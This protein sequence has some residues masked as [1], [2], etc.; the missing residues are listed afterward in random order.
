MWKLLL[1]G[2]L[3]DDKGSSGPEIRRRIKKASETFRRLWRVWAM[4]GLPLK[5]KGRLYSAFVHSMRLYN[6]EV[7]NIT[8]TE[9]KALVG[10]NGYLM[11]RLVGEVERSADNKRLAESQVLEMLGLESIQSLIRKRKLQWVAHCE[12]RGDKDRT[13]KRVVR[14]IEDEKSKFGGSRLKGDRKELRVNSI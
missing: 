2:S 9:M 14:E 6:C 10:R 7:W 8:E 11:R 13:W 1:F 3:I 12:R 4:K 5:L